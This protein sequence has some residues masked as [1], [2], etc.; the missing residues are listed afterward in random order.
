M[1]KPAPQNPKIAF[2]NFKKEQ[3]Q[4]SL[5]PLVQMQ[6]F[7]QAKVDLSLPLIAL[8]LETIP[9]DDP[10]L[11]TGVF[12]TLAL[13]KLIPK[14]MQI[15]DISIGNMSQFDLFSMDKTAQGDK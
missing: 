11:M 13:H 7:D 1:F 5:D 14:D 12:M 2:E 6:Q 10:M 8:G 15:A 3:V 4:W 9:S